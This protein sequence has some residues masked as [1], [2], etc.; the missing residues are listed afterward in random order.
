MS[1]EAGE[2]QTIIVSWSI[3]LF[4]LSGSSYFQAPFLQFFVLRP[5]LGKPQKKHEHIEDE[6]TWRYCGSSRYGQGL[7]VNECV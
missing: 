5:P 6:K 3:F 1:T 7:G 4:F 2:V